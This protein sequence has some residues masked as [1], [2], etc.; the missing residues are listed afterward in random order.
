MRHSLTAGKHARAAP[1]STQS[2]IAAA[3]QRA[4]GRTPV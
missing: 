1:L 2:L 3:L 4:F